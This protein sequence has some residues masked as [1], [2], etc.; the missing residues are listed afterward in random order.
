MVVVFIISSIF[1][2]TPALLVDTNVTLYLVVYTNV[3]LFFC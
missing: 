1:I 2:P 3:D